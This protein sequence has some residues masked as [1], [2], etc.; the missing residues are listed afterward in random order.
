MGNFRVEM[1]FELVFFGVWLGGFGC[2]RWSEAR[3]GGMDPFLL[4]FSHPLLEYKCK[5]CH[6]VSLYLGNY[7]FLE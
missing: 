1:G 3:E 4:Q 5:Y 2:G 7:I 6:C